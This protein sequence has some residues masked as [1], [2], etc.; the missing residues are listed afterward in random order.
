MKIA[1][2]GCAHGELDKIYESI[3]YIENHE[4]IKIDLLICCGD[5]QSVRN[6]ADMVS[7]AVPPKYQEMKDFCH[8]YTGQKKAP[9]LTL[10]IGG[11]HEAANYLWELPYGGW[12]A[13]NI[14]Y[15]GYAGVVNFAGFR[16]G[17]LSGIYKNRDYY[18]G[19]FESPPFNEDTKRSFYHVRSIDVARLKLLVDEPIDIFLSHDWPK[20]IYNH[21]DAEQLM[22]FKPFLRNEIKNNILGSDAAEDV[23]NTL[24]PKYW[25][26]GHMHAKF[27]AIVE[28]ETGETTKFLALDKCLPK[29]NFLQILDFGPATEEPVLKYDAQWLTVL[30][31]TN[32][33]FSNSCKPTFLT[34]LSE[35]Y[36]P[37]VEQ[38]DEVKQLDLNVVKFSTSVDGKNP[39]TISFC[40][41][42]GVMN[43][44]NLT[45]SIV[46]N[47]YGSSRRSFDKRRII[48]IP[49]PKQS[50]TSNTS[51]SDEFRD[52][53]FDKR[54]IID[55]PKP[56]QSD[57]S[58]TSGS[59]EFRDIV[60][61][62][63]S[64]NE[65][66]FGEIINPNVSS[67]PEEI[68]LSDDSSSDSSNTSSEDEEE[69]D[70]YTTEAPSFIETPYK[71]MT[72]VKK[73]APSDGRNISLTQQ[74][75][76]TPIKAPLDNKDT[77][78][79]DG[80]DIS[81]NDDSDNVSEAQ[82]PCKKFKLIRRNQ[83]IYTPSKEDI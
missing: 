50:D 39:Q 7:M 42:F 54:R 37:R 41:H 10:F 40:E 53:S 64:N 23:L 15:L 70:N 9:V 24:K 27:S 21:G 1:I 83:N 56:K 62:R 16:I 60:T 45:S 13:E 29:R 22:R 12:V 31:T 47:Q 4:N 28:H 11:N 46:N 66:E 61:P 32:E 30:K 25:F 33:M 49:K 78:S 58:N 18:K 52:Q 73:E 35:E 5:F 68:S 14:F 59:D 38:I 19:H 77:T 26:S 8:Y 76:E 17:G 63:L 44:C 65:D 72:D 79:S 43:P 36:K 2:E 34:E 75:V 20:N 57:T 67:N 71:V 3:E 51:G 81:F 80:G 69:H 74:F 48:D 55:I 6:Y 82:I